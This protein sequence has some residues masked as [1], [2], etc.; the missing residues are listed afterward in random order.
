M[1]GR[2][3]FSARD[4]LRAVWQA[5]HYRRAADA[6]TAIAAERAIARTLSLVFQHRVGIGR[7]VS[8]GASH[9]AS[10]PRGERRDEIF[11]KAAFAL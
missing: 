11:V 3:H 8:V 5:T 9:Q 10:E 4:S 1:A 7:H 2:L 6:A